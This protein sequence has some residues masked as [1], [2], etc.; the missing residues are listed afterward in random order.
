MYRGHEGCIMVN[1]LGLVGPVQDAKCLHPSVMNE[2]F[3]YSASLLDCFF[4]DG[5]V[6]LDYSISPCCTSLSLF[7]FWGKY[8]IAF[9]MCTSLIFVIVA[10][11][12]ILL[13]HWIWFWDN[14]YQVF[15]PF[16]MGLFCFVITGFYYVEICLILESQ[17][18]V[19]A[20]SE[21]LN[22]LHR[23]CTWAAWVKTRVPLDWLEPRGRI[24]MILA[25][26]E[27]KNVSRR[28]RL[29]KQV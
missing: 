24:A 11:F 5:W 12:R 20:W 16:S 28:Q 1:I 19:M 6:V 26:C 18:W 13:G 29:W 17:R 10:Y 3:L 2:I 4:Q 7:S 15:C 21:I 25:P 27:S 23:N 22:S 9:L 14:I 8:Y